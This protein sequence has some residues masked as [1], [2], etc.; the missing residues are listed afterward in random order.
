MAKKMS[1]SRR[2]RR[3][4]SNKMRKIHFVHKFI[5]YIQW[6]LFITIINIPH[7][8]TTTSLQTQSGFGVHE[9][10]HNGRVSVLPCSS[11]CQFKVWK[12]CVSKCWMPLFLPHSTRFEQ[13]HT[14]LHRTGSVEIEC[15][16]EFYFDF[17]FILVLCFYH[18]Y[19]H[20]QTIL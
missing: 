12:K 10:S 20:T 11:I 13:H 15:A 14:A 3:R 1:K 4:E 17:F 7:Y 5:T 2:R 18:N 8:T 16:I 19:M 9:K 6:I